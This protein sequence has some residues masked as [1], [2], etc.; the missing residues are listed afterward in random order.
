LLIVFL[1]SRSPVQTFSSDVS[2]SKII[3]AD[4]NGDG[5]E[6]TLF[7][8]RDG[9][10]FSLNVKIKDRTFPITPDKNSASIGSYSPY[11]PIRITLMDV[12]RDK[13]P[14]IF[15][16]ASIKDN[17][18]QHIFVWND[19]K[20]ENIF[21]NSNNILGFIDSKNNRTPKV[22]SGLLQGDTMWLSNY[23]F[24]NYKF[25][26]YNYNGDNA[27]MGKDTICSFVRFIQG[28]PYSKDY[29]PS[30]IF[31]SNSYE[32]NLPLINK[33]TDDNNTYVFQDGIFS[34]N[35]SNAKGEVT[36]VLW[37]LNFRGVSNAN[38]NNIKNYTLN[39]LL[40]PDENSKGNFYF[41]ISSIY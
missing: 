17:P 39:L 41:K 9:N 22:I 24:L 4:F 37:T 8:K 19:G 36:E 30:S 14:E 13:I 12:S 15:V 26:N 3:K 31:F 34:E 18:I 38:K 25:K 11:W 28:L 16:Q 29:I 23:I 40:T 27:F 5:K 7:V 1:L 6:D 21:S 20:F 2:N 32:R 33:L 35:K 10:K